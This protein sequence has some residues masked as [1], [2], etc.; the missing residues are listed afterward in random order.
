MF[1]HKR[2]EDVGSFQ[3]A[4][5]MNEVDVWDLSAQLVCW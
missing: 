2:T 3:E 5:V 4:C 1:I